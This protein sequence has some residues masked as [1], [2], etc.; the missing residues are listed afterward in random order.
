MIAAGEYIREVQELEKRIVEAETFEKECATN[1]KEAKAKSAKA[2]ED[3]RSYVRDT[4]TGQITLPFEP[5]KEN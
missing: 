4:E 1:H 5:G 2:W 3:L